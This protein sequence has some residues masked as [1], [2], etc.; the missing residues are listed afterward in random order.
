MGRRCRWNP[1][2][3][4]KQYSARNQT[5][6]AQSGNDQKKKKREK[7]RCA[8]TVRVGALTESI[9]ADFRVPGYARG[10]S[11]PSQGLNRSL[12]EESFTDPTAHVHV[13]ITSPLA[14]LR[15]FLPGEAPYPGGSIIAAR[16]NMDA[17]LRYDFMVNVFLIACG[18]GKKR[19]AMNTRPI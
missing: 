17:W 11:Q 1:R 5:V 15:Q 4:L 10:I 9:F 13:V 19:P 16:I 18:P 7:H 12:T 8:E 3:P 14:L 2:D 6:Y